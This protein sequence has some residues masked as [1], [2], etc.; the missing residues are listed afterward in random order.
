M[1]N[2]ITELHR[3]AVK[4]VWLDTTP[5]ELKQYSAHSLRVWACILLNETGKLSDYIKK[6]ICWLSD[7]FRV[8]LQDTSAI[9]LQHV[10]TL[11]KAL[12]EVMDLIS[13]FPMDVIT[14]SNSMTNSTKYTRPRHTRV[15]GQNGLICY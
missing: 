5:E 4:S 7:S 13:A 2:K 3:K 8:Y 10:D 1:G 9:Q 6:R 14:L 15:R 12:Q 11:R